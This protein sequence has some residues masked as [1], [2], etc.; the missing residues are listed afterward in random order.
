MAITCDGREGDDEYD[1]DKDG[2]GE[3]GSGEIYWKW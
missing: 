2:D 1:D 3:P